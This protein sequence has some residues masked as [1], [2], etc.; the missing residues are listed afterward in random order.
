MLSET[1]LWLLLALTFV[2]PTLGAILLR[3]FEHRIGDIGMV[4]GSSLLLL[5]A[6]VALLTIAR[7][8]LP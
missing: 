3:L 2:V 1:L 7:S 4:V 6:A 5:I 8:S